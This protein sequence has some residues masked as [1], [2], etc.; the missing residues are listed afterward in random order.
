MEPIYKTITG[1]HID[2]SRIVAMETSLACIYINFLLMNE[3]IV[4]GINDSRWCGRITSYMIGE[5]KCDNVAHEEYRLTEIYF[6]RLL[7]VWKKYKRE[8]K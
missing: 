7:N 2:L 6:N 3:P 5:G 4:L 8:E 1:V